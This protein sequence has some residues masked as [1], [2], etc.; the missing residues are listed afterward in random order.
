MPG[1]LRRHGEVVIS[2]SVVAVVSK[3]YICAAAVDT[4]GPRDLVCHFV[5]AEGKQGL[6]RNGVSLEKTFTE[7]IDSRVCTNSAI[8]RGT[9]K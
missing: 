2:S 1:V 8:F 3:V 5:F 6:K 7:N 4:R 9:D